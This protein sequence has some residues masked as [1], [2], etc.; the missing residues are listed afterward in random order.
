VGGWGG[1]E[2]NPSFLFS[3]LVESVNVVF[4]CAATVRFDEDLSKVS[5]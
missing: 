3:L 4:H 5:Y 2:N 1:W